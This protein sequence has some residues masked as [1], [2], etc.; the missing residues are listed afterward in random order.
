M[1]CWVCTS[2]ANKQSLAIVYCSRYVRKF[3]WHT[4]PEKSSVQS[5]VR[6]GVNSPRPVKGLQ[7][8]CGHLRRP[9]RP[10][11]NTSPRTGRQQSHSPNED[12]AGFARFC[13]RSLLPLASS[14]ALLQTFYNRLQLSK[15]AFSCNAL[16]GPP[17]WRE[18]LPVPCANHLVPSRHASR[19]GTI[20]HHIHIY[21]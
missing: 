19:L 15:Q 14:A 17:D 12:Q 11:T 5:G 1:L 7:T 16:M 4:K 21:A 8:P 13:F 6:D 9:T 10:P 20:R 3:G 2:V 18:W